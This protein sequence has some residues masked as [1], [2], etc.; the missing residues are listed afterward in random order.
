MLKERRRESRWRW[1]SNCS[2]F[3]GR[4]SSRARDPV[5]LIPSPVFYVS[6]S[7]YVC[8]K[9]K[10]QRARRGKLTLAFATKLGTLSFVK[11]SD[12]LTTNGWDSFVNHS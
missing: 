9:I 6:V 3:D 12:V 4:I 1:N 2:V 11:T 7:V 8:V 10:N 5:R